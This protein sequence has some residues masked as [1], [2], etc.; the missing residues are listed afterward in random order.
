MPTIQSID[1][2]QRVNEINNYVA[3]QIGGL[4][5]EGYHPDEIADYIFTAL[6]EDPTYEPEK[7]DERLLRRAIVR[8]LT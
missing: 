5:T 3:E 4:T 6:L 2:V 1:H 7:D 8:T